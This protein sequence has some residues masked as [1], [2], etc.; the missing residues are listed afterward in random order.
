MAEG[1]SSTADHLWEHGVDEQ[2]DRRDSGMEERL[3]AGS[4]VIAVLGFSM[5]LWGA[6]LVPV[7]GV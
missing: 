1:S 7:I 5:L 4:A 2:A 6:I 3:P